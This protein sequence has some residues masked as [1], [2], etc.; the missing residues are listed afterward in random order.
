M[1]IF[2]GW[3]L[4]G[5]AALA[6]PILPAPYSCV[7]VPLKMRVEH[8]QFILAGKVIDSTA[9]TGPIPSTIYHILPDKVWRGNKADTLLIKINHVHPV[10][11]AIGTRYVLVMAEAD[12]ALGNCDGVYAGAEAT[13][14][15][16]QLDQLFTHRRY[17]RGPAPQ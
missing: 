17:R 1:N 6:S 9:T 7:D 16:A 3:L 13:K 15:S 8:A 11:L 10:T 5:L 2:S 12:S 14:I 4:A